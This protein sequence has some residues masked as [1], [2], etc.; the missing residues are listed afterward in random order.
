MKRFQYL[1]LDSE[2]KQQK[3]ISEAQYKLFKD[4]INVANNNRE[5]GA[6][7]ED[8]VWVEDGA[9]AKDMK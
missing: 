1:P 5:D 2:L 7:A 6:K 3:D 9:K 4:Q 8:G